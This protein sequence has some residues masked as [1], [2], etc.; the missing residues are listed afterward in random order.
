MARTGTSATK[1]SETQLKEY[2][3]KRDFKK[4]AEP[5]GAVYAKK[6]KRLEFVIQKHEASHLHYDVRLEVA[7]VMKSWACPK[8]PSFDTSVKRLAVQV[9]DHPT[10]YNTFE[11]TIPKGEYG[12]GTVMV[13][14]Y[15]YYT[16]DDVQKGEDPEDVMLKG[17]EKGKLAFT[18]HG[19]KLR[20]SFTLVRTRSQGTSKPQ[21]L[22]IKHRDEFADPAYDPVSEEARSAKTDRTMREIEAGGDVY[23]QEK[24]KAKSKAKS[25]VKT[26]KSKSKSKSKSTKAS[27]AKKKALKARKTV[28]AK[29]AK[30]KST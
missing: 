13:W 22:L 21:W 25:K 20:G 30:R 4:T 18:F 27:A 26:S 23:G 24:S 11:G 15:G 1:R 8:G 12:G 9:E 2:N 3:R 17:I 7:G 10:S 6:S 14:D 16:V 5:A 28:K 19:K 29:T